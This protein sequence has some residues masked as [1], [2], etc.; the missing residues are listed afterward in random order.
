M[1]EAVFYHINMKFTHIHPS[2][3]TTINSSGRARAPLGAQSRVPR[4]ITTHT[5][6]PREARN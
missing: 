4:H 1:G 3:P 6:A 2:T 5:T